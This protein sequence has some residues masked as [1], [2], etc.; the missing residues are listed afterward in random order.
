MVWE[1]A[2]EEQQAL[3]ARESLVSLHSIKAISFTIK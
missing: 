2:E 1:P 3:R